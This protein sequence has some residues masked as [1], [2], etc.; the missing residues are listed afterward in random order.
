M[1]VFKNYFKI[2]KKHWI[3]LMIYALSSLLI[4]FAFSKTESNNAGYESIK[5]DIFLQ[6]ESE[7]KLAKSLEEYLRKNLNVI[8]HDEKNIEDDLFYGISSAYVKITKDFDKTRKVEYKS[9]PNSMYGL[10]VKD[11]INGFL[12]KVKSYETANFN[13]DDTIKYSL[14]DLEKKIDVSLAESNKADKDQSNKLYFN[15]INYS[16]LSLVI[17]IISTIMFVYNKEMI[18]KRNRVSPLSQSKQS[19]QLILGHFVAGFMVCIAF[20]LLYWII[21]KE[22]FYLTSTRLMML[23][24]LIFTLTSICMAMFISSLIKNE[25]VLAGIMNVVSLGSSFLCGAFVPQ[26]MLSDTTL[27][28]ARVLPSY[29]YISNNIKISENP[30]IESMS[31]NSFIMVAFAIIFIILTIIIKKR[32]VTK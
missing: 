8:E 11:K 16:I 26:E 9:A 2:A 25:N 17:F 10:L 14:D 7:S 5:V 18:S 23:N 13:I 19:L 12:N 29:Y 20:C 22:K 24:S 6:N 28:I 32:E 31:T 1:T 30:A 4:V 21:G 27:K 15:F 3:S